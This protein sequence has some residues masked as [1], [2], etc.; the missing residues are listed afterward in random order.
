VD[1]SGK[2]VKTDAFKELQGMS[3]MDLSSQ[4]FTS[5]ISEYSIGADEDECCPLMSA[6]SSLSQ[7]S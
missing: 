6:L 4:L 1:I 3:G 2:V 7:E 5:I